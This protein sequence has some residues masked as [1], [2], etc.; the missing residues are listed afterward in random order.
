MLGQRVHI[1][2][3]CHHCRAPLRFAVSPDAPAPE[4]EGVMVW[5]GEYAENCGRAL[6]SL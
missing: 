2:A 1:G 6:D 4:S 3:S 5:F